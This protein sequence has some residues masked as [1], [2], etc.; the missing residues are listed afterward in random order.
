MFLAARVADLPG[1]DPAA[2]GITSNQLSKTLPGSSVPI[3]KTRSFQMPDDD[4][5]PR[6]AGGDAS[7]PRSQR[8]SILV[9][10]HGSMVFLFCSVWLKL[11]GMGLASGGRCLVSIQSA[12]GIADAHP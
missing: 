5:S 9:L 3:G 1:V 6:R 4:V 7:T 12:I 8:A 11:Q 2:A 10:V